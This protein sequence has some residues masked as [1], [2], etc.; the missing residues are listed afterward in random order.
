MHTLKRIFF[1]LKIQNKKEKIYDLQQ[2]LDVQD[3]AIHAILY[4]FIY[5]LRI[6]LKIIDFFEFFT[7]NI[8]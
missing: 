1:A 6:L 7:A 8:C 5:L 3:N 4:L 2:A